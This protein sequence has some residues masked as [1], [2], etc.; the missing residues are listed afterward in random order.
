MRFDCQELWVAFVLWYYLCVMHNIKYIHQLITNAHH[1]STP[2]H[3]I[4]NQD[5]KSISTCS[6]GHDLIRLPKR[7]PNYYVASNLP[8]KSTPIYDTACSKNIR[9]RPHVL[10][11]LPYVSICVSLREETAL[12]LPRTWEYIQSVADHTSHAGW[13]TFTDFYVSRR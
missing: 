10:S 1:P 7:N 5:A 3:M 8:L 4:W 11:E 13:A 2:L 6:H 9:S 12:P